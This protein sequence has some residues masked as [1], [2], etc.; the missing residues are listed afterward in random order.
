MRPTVR[1]LRA[2]LGEPPDHT[3]LAAEFGAFRT[4][5]GVL[6]LSKADEAFEDLVELA[7]Y[8]GFRLFLNLMLRLLV[9][10][11]APAASLHDVE[12]IAHADYFVIV[13]NV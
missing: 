2:L 10:A 3:V 5:D 12:A 7:A 6:D 8:F 1:A 11:A 9:L 13:V 4:E